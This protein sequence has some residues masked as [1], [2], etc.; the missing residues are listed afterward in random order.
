MQ[1]MLQAIRTYSL[2]ASVASDP[3]LQ[4]LGLRAELTRLWHAY[5]NSSNNF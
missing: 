2:L 4:H 1:S 3:L 5:V